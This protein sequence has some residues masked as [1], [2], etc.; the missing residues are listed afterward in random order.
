MDELGVQ[1]AGRDLGGEGCRFLRFELASGEVWVRRG[2]ALSI[3]PLE[4]LQ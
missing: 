4:A 2:A 1:V 3:E